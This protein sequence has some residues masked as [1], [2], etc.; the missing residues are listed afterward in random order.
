[1]L[2]IPPLSLYIHFPWCIRKCPY[3]DF[4]SYPIHGSIPQAEYLTALLTDLDQDLSKVTGRELTS[5]FIGGGTPSLFS[6]EMVDQLLTEISKRIPIQIDAEMTLEANPRT[7]D[8][9]RFQAFRAAGINR[10]SLGIQSFNDIQLQQLG[11]I[12]NRQDAITAIHAARSAGFE[13]FNLDLMFGLPTQT[14]MMALQDLE[15]ALSFQPS[16]LSW[17][18]LTIE[19]DTLFYQQPPILPNDETM[20]NIYTHGQAYLITQGYRPY[21]ISAYTRS[22]QYCH[23]NLN[24][25]NFGD[26]LGIGAGAHGK[27][28]DSHTKTIIRTV[29]PANLE[30]YLQIAQTAG[31]MAEIMLL[32]KAE[33]CLEFMM[34]ALRLYDGF[35]ITQFITRTGFNFNEVAEPLAQAKQH[36]WLIEENQRIVPTAKGIQFLNDLLDLFVV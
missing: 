29:K 18:Q 20:W 30:Q 16:H 26:Y 4:N 36:G 7:V 23:H 34:N 8:Y 25:W 21:E 28:T 13:N 24:Y 35:T 33:I 5:I 3:C 19:P 27:I 12:H 17:Y 10:L 1:M 32:T 22:A 31:N 2:Q 9:H 15:T 11:R 6:P 14:V